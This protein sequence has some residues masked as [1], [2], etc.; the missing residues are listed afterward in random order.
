M[1]GAVQLAV[2]AIGRLHLETDAAKLN[3]AECAIVL[4]AGI[5]YDGTPGPYLQERL[6]TAINLYNQGYV[7]KLL[8]S[9]DNGQEDY[10]EVTSM[11][12]YVLNAGV[13]SSDIFLDYAGFSTYESMYRAKAIFC[14]NTAI[15]VTQEF[16]EYRAL[17]T[18]VI[19]GLKVQ[20][21]SAAPVQ[22]ADTKSL[23]IREVLA[24]E[25]D[26]FQA[27]F[28]IKPTYLGNQIPITGDGTD[29][30]A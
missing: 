8:L 24:R 30:W 9:G 26:F 2:L 18:G 11:K 1:V 22:S 16:H 20:G 19:L 6:E 15:V 4:G 13:P 28:K 29:S 23:I 21:Y 25:K 3:H 10:D 12:N 14:V 17:C 5:Y 27:L 7:D